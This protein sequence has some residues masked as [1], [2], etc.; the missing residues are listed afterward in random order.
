MD[1]FRARVLLS[2]QRALLG[3][4]FP[5]LRA[6]WV[7]WSEREIRI[8]WIVD[9]EVSGADRESISSVEAEVQADFDADVFVGSETLER[10]APE[11]ILERGTCVFARRE[12]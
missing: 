6:V 9:Q 4:V 12:S 2:M 8:R 10:R 11:P 3:E 5:S 7:E 1:P